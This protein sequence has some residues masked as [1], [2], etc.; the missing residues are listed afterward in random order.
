[1]ESPLLKIAPTSEI[2]ALD[3]L[4]ITSPTPRS[5]TTLLQRLLCSSPD[6]LIF[7]EKVA[8]DLEF[9]LNIYMY[10]VQEYNFQREK[11]QS[12]IEKVLHGDVNGWIPNLIPDVDGYLG[13]MYQS[14]FAGIAY[15]REFARNAGRPIWGFKYPGWAPA[16]IQL[17]HSVLP[18]ARFI[19]IHRDL[20]SSMKSAKAHHLINDE[21]EARD[22]CQKWAASMVY[23]NST[24]R[25][26]LGLVIDFEDL[27]GHSK[28]TLNEIARYTGV[29]GMDW[30]VL[31][32]K[33]NDS[34]D[35]E[36]AGKAAS[37]YTPPAQ[38]DPVELSIALETQNAVTLI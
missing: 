15:C 21:Q 2:D 26:E 14:A 22:F 32:Q 24:A 12:D 1:M 6:A 36:L 31:D 19:F 7:G 23:L 38:L 27:A 25:D 9:F 4:I 13:A 29:I 3:P 35:R 11:Y 5:G 30:S 34:T 8:Y 33:I 16:T 20:I 17:I 10:K 28:I 37:R 18:K